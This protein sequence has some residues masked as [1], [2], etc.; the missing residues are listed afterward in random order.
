[1]SEQDEN[2]N[3][4]D[5]QNNGDGKPAQEAKAGDVKALPQWAQDLISQVRGEAANYRTQ[6]R[7]S[8]N[9]L[10][11]AKTPED[12]EKATTEL[13]EANARLE[14]DLLIERVAAKHGLPEDLKGRLKGDT[15]KDLETDAAALAKFAPKVERKVEPENL[16]GG[17]YPDDSGDSFDPVAEAKKARTTRY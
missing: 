6:L 8:Q 2:N 14:R 9:A 15:E 13:R 17:L 16:S 1:M 4:N 5:E 12:I 3:Q 11:K 10:E 7:E